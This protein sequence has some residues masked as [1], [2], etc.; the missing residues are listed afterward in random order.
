MNAKLRGITAV[1]RAG[2][3]REAVYKCRRTLSAIMFNLCLRGSTIGE[4]EDTTISSPGRSPKQP[5]PGIGLHDPL[6]GHQAG[7]E[8]IALG[9]GVGQLCPR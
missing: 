3:G 2:T 1:I 4:G 6:H 5:L 9:Q 8:F 7:P